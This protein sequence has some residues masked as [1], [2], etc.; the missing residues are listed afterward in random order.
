MSD[1]IKEVL[2]RP[3]LG[4]LT[5]KWMLERP[6]FSRTEH[7]EELVAKLMSI[8]NAQQDSY[9]NVLV[10]VGTGSQ[11]LFSAHTDT[12]HKHSQKA[13]YELEVE[14]G[15]CSRKDGGVL[16][17]DC[18]V[19]I[20]LMLCMIEQGVEGTYVWHRDEEI[21]GQGGVFAAGLLQ[22]DQ[23]LRAIA[24]DRAGTSDIIT[25]MSVGRTCS[26]EFADALAAE[27][28]LNR[29][30]HSY[31][32][33]AMGVFTDTASYVD[34]IAEC[35]NI[36]VG[37]YAEHTQFESCDLNFVQWLEQ[38]LCELSWEDLPVHRA[39]GS[40]DDTPPWYDYTFYNVPQGLPADSQ[41]LAE[42]DEVIKQYPDGVADYLHY[43]LGVDAFEIQEWLN[44]SH[45]AKL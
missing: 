22:R 33:C 31:A 17:A 42:L 13:L 11:T 3:L 44:A 1:V 14:Q 16:G 20:Y 2:E 5:L 39:A 37:Y 43:E 24:F 8:P 9:G 19:G 23:Y 12:V 27:L 18:A 7:E 36:S 35:T 34:V 10:H 40:L 4:G 32:R 45:S 21:G 41:A 30:V 28:N 29:G 38:T 25:H 15:I 26:D 6:R